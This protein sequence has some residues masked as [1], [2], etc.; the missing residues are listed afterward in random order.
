M[1][2]IKDHTGLVHEAYAHPSS[3]WCDTVCGILHDNTGSMFEVDVPATCL[4]CAAGSDETA[5][6]SPNQKAPVQSWDDLP[7]LAHPGALCLV[8]NDPFP[9]ANGLW[10]FVARIGWCRVEEGGIQREPRKMVEFNIKV[11]YE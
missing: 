3:E 2:S 10:C 1:I 8:L 7:M 9:R 5:R 11:G 6:L 4:A